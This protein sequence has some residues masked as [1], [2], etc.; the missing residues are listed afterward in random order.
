MIGQVK[1]KAPTT[2]R[3][4]F[5]CHESSKPA[6]KASFKIIHVPNPAPARRGTPA[7]QCQ[8][9]CPYSQRQNGQK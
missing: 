5:A 6:L 3:N 8:Q 2:V 9:L 7:S 1:P 4:S